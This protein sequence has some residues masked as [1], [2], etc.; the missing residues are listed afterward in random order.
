MVCFCNAH[1]RNRNDSKSLDD[2]SKWIQSQS[3][4]QKT[5]DS[6]CQKYW[7]GQQWHT[8]GTGYQ[9][10]SCSIYVLMS[11][12]ENNSSSTKCNAFKCLISHDDNYSAKCII[13][14]FKVVPKPLELS[15]VIN[16]LEDPLTV[17]Q[18]ISSYLDYKTFFFKRL[19][20][21]QQS[22]RLANFK[23]NFIYFIF[24]LKG[25]LQER[26]L[27]VFKK[28]WKKCQRGFVSFYLHIFTTLFIWNNMSRFC[29]VICDVLDTGAVNIMSCCWQG[30]K[31]KLIPKIPI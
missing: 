8:W 19:Y 23:T 29:N 15:R 5:W 1:F 28:L 31:C 4:S 13:F 6:T 3:S 18:S 10:L 12:S 24:F 30:L 9:C 16:L 27:F 14:L 2:N 21:Y 25:K 22:T 26:H 20:W 7:N 17:S 11:Y